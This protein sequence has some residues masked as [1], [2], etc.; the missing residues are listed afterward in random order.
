MK[1]HEEVLKCFKQFE[2]EINLIKVEQEI[3]K[4]A[5]QESGGEKV[6]L[7]KTIVELPTSEDCLTFFSTLQNVH[8]KTIDCEFALFMGEKVGQ[9]LLDLQ[10]N[11]DA[12]EEMPS[13]R[14]F[15]DSS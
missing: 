8:L 4:K 6:N 13:V 11:L 5:I 2:D 12:F 14:H 1:F 9:S 3:K 7:S 10:I 15:M